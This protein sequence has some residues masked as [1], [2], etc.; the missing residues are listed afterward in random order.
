MP[1]REIL[2]L[3][4]PW[5]CTIRACSAET[6]GRSIATQGV[7]DL[8]VT[9]AIMRLAD[10]GDT[11]LD[12][13][14]NIGYMSLVL[15]RSVGPR[16]RVASFE[17]SP[18]VFP[19]LRMNVDNW[20]S[21]GIAPIEIHGLALS[22]SDGEGH[23]GFPA[24]SDENWG[25]ATLE[26][27]DGGIPI[28]LRR[29]DS[30][31]PEGAGIMKVDVEGHEASVFAGASGLLSRKRIRDILFEEH[32]PYPARSHSI[33]LDHGYQLYRLT[34]STG[35]PLLLPASA[36]G[37]QAYLPSNFLATAD[38]ARAESRF[39]APGWQALS[40]GVHAHSST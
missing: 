5:D 31:E 10:P 38:P 15:A 8:P 28:Q 32:E 24:N 21:L 29:L 11:A 25:L 6:I 13:G 1:S 20:K 34:R 36:P 3:S 7:Y 18:T 23:L 40:K 27:R 16:G 22:E 33:L 14:A 2:P 39:R 4:L 17:P 30:A 12:V 9:E 26:I 19:V 35:R 37:R